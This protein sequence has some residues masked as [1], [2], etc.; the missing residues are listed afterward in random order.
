MMP[1]PT[2]LRTQATTAGLEIL[3]S[4]EF[5]ESYSRTLRAWRSAFNANWDEIAKLGFDQRFYRMWNFYL[6]V[7]AACFR[8]GSTDVTQISLRRTT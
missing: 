4:M 7:C 1:S 2:A 8:A 6:A 3:G 5:S